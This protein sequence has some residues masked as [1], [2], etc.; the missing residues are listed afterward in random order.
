MVDLG[1][2]DAGLLAGAV[3]SAAL[4]ALKIYEW[5]KVEPRRTN[6]HCKYTEAIARDLFTRT[7]RDLQEMRE[8]STDNHI[9]LLE[10]FNALM[11]AVKSHEAEEVRILVGLQRESE[12]QTSIFREFLTELRQSRFTR[13]TG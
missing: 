4:V 3:V 13:S 12:A 1:Q 10:A 11:I 7:E 5:K 2:L 6:G 9:R 8:V